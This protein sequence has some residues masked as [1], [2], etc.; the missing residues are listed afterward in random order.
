MTERLSTA[1]TAKT[2]TLNFLI[3]SLALFVLC[4]LSMMNAQK[5][6]REEQITREPWHD[7][8]WPLASKQDSGKWSSRPQS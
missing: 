8:M 2:R 7:R 5:E 1:H 3:Q 6:D 4:S